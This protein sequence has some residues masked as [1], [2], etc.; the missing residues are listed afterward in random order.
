[1]APE[2]RVFLHPGQATVYAD[3]SRFRVVCAGRR[4]GKSELACVELIARAVAGPPGKYWY[5]APTRVLAK[6]TLWH[7]LKALTDPTWWAKDPM[8][9]E[10]SISLTSGAEIKL[11]GAEDP[12]ALRG[13]GLRFAVLDEYA[14][15][16]PET[17]SEVL[18]PALTD[19]LAPA[20]FIGTPKGFGPFYDL[21]ALGQAGAPDWRSWQFRTVD[22]PTIDA[23]EIEAARAEMDARTYR[24]E[25]EASF[26]TVSG[27]A[28]YAFRRQDHVRPVTIDP[29][30][31]VCVSFDFNINPATA[32][33][34][35]RLHDEI[36]VWREVWITHAGGEATRAAA[37]RVKELLAQARWFG[38]TRVYGDPA[39][40]AQKTTG[41]SDHQ[42]LRDLFGGSTWHI[43][44]AA[45]HVRDRV[46]AVN[47][48]LETLDG[49]RHVRVD[50]SCVHLIAD[51]EQVTFKDTGELDKSAPLLT[52]VSDAFG[53]WLEYE[54][55][56]TRSVVAAIKVPR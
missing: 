11:Q 2:A 33:I 12:D 6:D 46:A 55:S 13:R 53:Y 39:G 41:P 17:W 43:R 3:P 36:R 37:V 34:G 14:D 24:Q 44:S 4:W 16:R 52:H 54:F 51:L 7:R 49:R 18:R 22:N 28:Y 38:Q 30:L 23:R 8:E 35:Q 1:M 45:P 25:F 29:A 19:Y 50:P 56:A 27:R 26:E 42:V 31:P 32:V 10:L 40:R 21:F 47:G 9:T 15:M 48:R 5:I 20:L